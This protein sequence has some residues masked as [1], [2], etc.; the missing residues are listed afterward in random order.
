[1]TKGENIHNVSKKI[2]SFLRLKTIIIFLID[3]SFLWSPT[4]GIPCTLF[5]GIENSVEGG[6]VLIGKTRDRP[7]TLEQIFIEV[8]TKGGYR[9]R[10][11]STKGKTIVTSGINEKG[12][13]VSVLLPRRSFP[14]PLLWMGCSR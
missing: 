7:K 5:G 8:T 2:R 11:I 4:K 3:I 13:V 10:G 14:K 6:G 12:L 9:Y 1:M